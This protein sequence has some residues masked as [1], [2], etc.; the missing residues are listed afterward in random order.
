MI[1]IPFT[2]YCVATSSR[3]IV[4]VTIQCI[5]DCRRTVWE[6]LKLEQVRWRSGQD[7]I[8]FVQKGKGR[9]SRDDGL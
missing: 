1:V 5:Y 8:I 4:S 9:L 7:D 6:P 3:E 2:K